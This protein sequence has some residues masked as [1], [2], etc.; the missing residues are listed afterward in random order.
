MRGRG[1]Q[2]PSM[3]MSQQLCFYFQYFLLYSALGRLRSPRY[4]LLHQSQSVSCHYV[5]LS[6]T[7]RQ[8]QVPS[9]LH[10]GVRDTLPYLLGATRTR[11]Q[12]W[13]GSQHLGRLRRGSSAASLGSRRL[14]PLALACKGR[15]RYKAKHGNKIPEWSL[16]RNSPLLLCS[17]LGRG[18]SAGLQL[19]PAVLGEEKRVALLQGF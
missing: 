12:R 2:K 14:M 13:S 1:C 6:H 9:W 10:A 8:T 4:F 15:D 18:D 19:S 7:S 16:L 17:R 11:L 5:P 3:K